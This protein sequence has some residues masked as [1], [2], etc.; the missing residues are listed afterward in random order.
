V[1]RACKHDNEN[2]GFTKGKK[3]L[4]GSATISF[5]QGLIGLVPFLDYLSSFM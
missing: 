1:A 2:L 3:L 4:D 5:S